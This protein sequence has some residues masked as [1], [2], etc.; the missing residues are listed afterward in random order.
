[1]SVR[2]FLFSSFQESRGRRP[3]LSRFYHNVII[4]PSGDFCRGCSVMISRLAYRSRQFWNTLLAPSKH[5]PSEALLRHLTPA[6]LSL[7]QRMQP[8]EQAHAYQIF[9]RLETDGQTDPD[10]LAAALLHDVGK[11]LHPLSICNRVMIVLGKHLFPGA[12]RHWAS[13]TPRGLRLPFVVSAQHAGWGAE[14]ATQAGA[15]SKTVEL[16]RHHH[17]AYLLNPDSPSKHL[18]AALQAADDES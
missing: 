10:L 18:L 8:S 7:F 16:V 2:R 6:Q 12:A 11:I 14:L 17:D 4:L 9:K 1:M 3:R 13:G 5:I 15:T